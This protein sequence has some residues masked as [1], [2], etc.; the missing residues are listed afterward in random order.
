[1]IEKIQKAYQTL[2]VQLQ[3]QIW[4][5]QKNTKGY[6]FRIIATSILALLIFQFVFFAP[7]KE[8]KTL[9]FII[10]IF[11]IATG[12]LLANALAGLFLTGIIIIAMIIHFYPTLQIIT[13]QATE[14]LAFAVVCST[15]SYII[16]KSK[17]QMI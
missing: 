9:S 13:S 10:G 4:F 14:L 16:E 2:A 17:K 11:A 7:H 15:I 1:M 12:S 3:D 6:A 8:A 5:P